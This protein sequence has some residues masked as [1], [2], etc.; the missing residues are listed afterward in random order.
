MDVA[1]MV[2]VGAT[3]ADVAAETALPL[4]LKGPEN[5]ESTGGEK[6]DGATGGTEA[7]T[8]GMEKVGGGDKRDAVSGIMEAGAETEEAATA[9]LAVAVAVAM[10]SITED[11]VSDV[12][13]AEAGAW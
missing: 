11:S 2:I 4:M 12:A 5:E 6:S 9:A 7:V 3:G 10:A 8:G 1:G 13:D